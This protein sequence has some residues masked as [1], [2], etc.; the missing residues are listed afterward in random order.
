MKSIFSRWLPTT[1]RNHARKAVLSVAGLAILGGVFVGPATAA[2]AG[3]SAPAGQQALAVNYQQQPNYYY[4]GPAATRIALTA[5]GKTI[6]MD[7]L[8][9]QLGTTSDGTNSAADITRV[10]N[11]DTGDGFYKTHK[12]PG[13]TATAAEM[14]QLKAD[15]VHAISYDHPVVANVAGSVTDNAGAVHSYQG[16]HYLTVVGYTDGGLTVKISDPA[17]PV[18][19]GSYTM[20]VASLANWIATRGYS[21]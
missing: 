18:G 9:K 2:F 7:T 16:G 13:Q 5:L 10:L 1:A 12:I 15:V 17:D 11:S 4:C 19:N 3:P 21:A 20:P 14:D 6:S 8:A